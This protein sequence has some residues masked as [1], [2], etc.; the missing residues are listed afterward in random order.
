MNEDNLRR[1]IEEV[2]PEGKIPQVT[3]EEIIVTLKNLDSDEK[4]I[5]ETGVPT[6][7]LLDYLKEQLKLD[8]DWRKRAQIAAK[9]I[10]LGL[11]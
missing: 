8:L 9:I 1:A 7:M 6:G 4:K 10:S 5:D 2:D 3:L 11:E